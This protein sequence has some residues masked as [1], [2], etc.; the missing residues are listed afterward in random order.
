MDPTNPTVTDLTDEIDV[1]LEAEGDADSDSEAD[2]GLDQ[3][4]REGTD[5]VQVQLNPDKVPASKNSETKLF[6]GLFCLAC[7]VSCPTKEK[8]EAHC[9]C[10]SHHSK[11]GTLLA[12]VDHDPTLC[13]PDKVLQLRQTLVD[14]PIS[15]KSPSKKRTLSGGILVPEKEKAPVDEVDAIDAML[16]GY[17]PPHRVSPKKTKGPQA[18]ENVLTLEKL[19]QCAQDVNARGEGPWYCSICE[20]HLAHSFQW[21][22]HF[23][24]ETGPHWPSLKK[25]RSK[26]VNPE[27]PRHD[28]PLSRP[29]SSP[30]TGALALKVVHRSHKP[31]RPRESEGLPAERT[32]V[33]LRGGPVAPGR[34]SE[35]LPVE[36]T[37]VLLR[38]APVAPG[39]WP[40]ALPAT[41]ARTN[42]LMEAATLTHPDFK[43]MENAKAMITTLA[44]LYPGLPIGRSDTRV[45]DPSGHLLANSIE[46]ITFSDH[47]PY[48]ETSKIE[49]VEKLAGGEESKNGF[50]T[51]YYPRN[52]PDT[53]IYKQLREVDFPFP[54][55]GVFAVHVRKSGAYAD[56]KVGKFYIPLFQTLLQSPTDTIYHG[57]ALLPAAICLFNDAKPSGPPILP[58]PAHLTANQGAGRAR[59]NKLRNERSA[60][61]PSWSSSSSSAPSNSSGSS[62]SSSDRSSSSSD[63]SASSTHSTSDRHADRRHGRGHDSRRHE[64]RSHERSQTRDSRKRNLSPP[65]AGNAKRPQ[66]TTKCPGCK[67]EFSVPTHCFVFCPNC[68][69]GFSV[70]EK[71]Y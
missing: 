42:A 22:V 19:I 25:Y 5:S 3:K 35:G 26:L 2:N 34:E 56:Y 46:R 29:T 44:I 68:S 38:G 20:K 27:V 57:P 53:R 16:K 23:N 17:Q 13:P 55:H 33:L 70:V 66:I 48:I 30:G 28:G 37:S 14:F 62:S 6:S 69:G 45:L 59:S 8:L 71:K 64:R 36:R 58:L 32:S 61:L 60:A 4:E 18:H 65:P 43:L 54:P 1:D 40:S 51:L 41:A 52:H 11:S 49:D 12:A 15:V 24:P 67:H 63:R 47:G 39:P 7:H 21:D 9:R 10:K 31:S 50:F